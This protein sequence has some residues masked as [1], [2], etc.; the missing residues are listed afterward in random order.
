MIWLAHARLR[1]E[2]LK[3]GKYVACDL[4]ARRTKLLCPLRP[5]LRRGRHTSL[6]QSQTGIE[7]S[8]STANYCAKQVKRKH[9]LARNLMILRKYFRLSPTS[10]LQPEEFPGSLISS[11]TYRNPQLIRIKLNWIHQTDRWPLLQYYKVLMLS[12]VPW[13]PILFQLH[14][15]KKWKAL[16]ILDKGQG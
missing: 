14:I 9:F 16:Y 2:K 7:L 8:K 4:W 15:M 11:T 1:K 6:L 12:C 10:T 5:K 13:W 3:D